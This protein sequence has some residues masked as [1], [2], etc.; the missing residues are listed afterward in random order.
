MSTVYP[1]RNGFWTI[2]YATSA[3]FLLL[4]SHEAVM[5]ENIE[6]EGQWPS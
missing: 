1:Q 6:S 3:M 5:S 4:A 2:A